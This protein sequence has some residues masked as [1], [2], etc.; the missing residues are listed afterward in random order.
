MY[1]RISALNL[2]IGDDGDLSAT[3]DAVPANDRPAPKQNGKN[4][5]TPT[6]IAMKTFISSSY[7]HGWKTLD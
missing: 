4:A 1:M 2:K 5:K 7:P 3:G 6:R